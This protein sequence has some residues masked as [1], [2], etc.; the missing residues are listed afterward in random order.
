MD[1]GWKHSQPV[2][3]VD[4]VSATQSVAHLRYAGKKSGLYPTDDM[5]ALRV[6]EIL[7]IC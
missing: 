2:L 6:D 4:G 5:Q 1:H 7:D 3:E